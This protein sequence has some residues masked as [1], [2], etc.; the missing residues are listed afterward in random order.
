MSDWTDDRAWCGECGDELDLV[1]PGKHNP[2]ENEECPS[3]WR[4]VEADAHNALNG[5][6]SHQ[7]KGVQSLISD[8]GSRISDL[9]AQLALHWTSDYADL[10][11]RLKKRFGKNVPEGDG[12]GWEWE[13]DPLAK[14][15]IAAIET[16][17]AERDDWIEER[18]ESH[19]RLVLHYDTDPGA[20]ATSPTPLMDELA[21]WWMRQESPQAT[22]ARLEGEVERT[23]QAW[24]DGEDPMCEDV[25]LIACKGP[26]GALTSNKA[27][28]ES[29]AGDNE[30]EDT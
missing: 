21:D 1:R 3:W 26:C 20:S 15:A 18:N 24:V 7:A 6:D 4:G 22:I 11:E 8:M 16:L 27:P 2:C 12:W 19:V 9:Q 28:E 30:Q 25:C 10:V 23:R 14:E 29:T 5:W 17:V 13:V